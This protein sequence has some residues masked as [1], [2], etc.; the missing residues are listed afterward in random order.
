MIA[1]DLNC[2]DITT[3]DLFKEAGFTAANDGS[4]LT[5]PAASENKALDHIL[6]KGLSV[7]NAKAHETT[8]SDHYAL[9]ADVTLA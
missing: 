8:L 9:T 7:K 3:L 1:G 5:C 6:V 4:L 2:R